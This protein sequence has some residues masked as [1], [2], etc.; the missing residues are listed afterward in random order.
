MPAKPQCCPKF[1]LLGFLAAKSFWS[2]LDASAALK[3]HLS[4]TSCPLNVCRL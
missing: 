2:L 4:S 3:A 1:K